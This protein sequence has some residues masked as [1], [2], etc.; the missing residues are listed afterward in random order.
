MLKSEFLIYRYSGDTIVPRR[1]E[2]NSGTIAIARELIDTFTAFVR[3]AQKELDEKIQEL[4]EDSPDYKVRRGLCHILKN[5]FATFEIISPIEPALLR[6][7]VF[8]TAASSIPLPRAKKKTIEMVASFLSE[9][10]NR[11]VLPVEVEGGL[12]ADLQENRILTEFISPTPEELLH[13]YNLAQVQG[14]FY[15]ATHVIVN[16]YRNDPGE[17]KLLFRYH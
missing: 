1:L 6:E 12:Y 10:L 3:K 9:Q 17:Y 11:E 5:N 13:R 8:T 15:K 2:I 4:E 14:V 7:K 16:A